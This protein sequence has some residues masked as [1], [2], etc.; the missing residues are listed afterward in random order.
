MT[1]LEK[2]RQMSAEEMAEFLQHVARCE[3]S[4]R[5]ESC[6]ANFICDEIITSAYS[7]IRK[8]NEEAKE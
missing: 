8:L 4:L 7:I 2:I 5:C 3:I 6:V 1:N